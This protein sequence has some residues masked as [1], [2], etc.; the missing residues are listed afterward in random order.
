[1]AWRAE[2]LLLYRQAVGSWT[3]GNP[4]QEKSR[5]GVI[6]KIFISFQEAKVNGSFDCP[7]GDLC[8]PKCCG[9]SD[10]FNMETMTCTF[11]NTSE[12]LKNMDI[13]ELDVDETH[14]NFSLVPGKMRSIKLL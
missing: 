9:P 3:L 6:Q 4:K 13:Y 11:S 2:A 12:V 1:M 5:S 8:W 10:I 7:E 14:V